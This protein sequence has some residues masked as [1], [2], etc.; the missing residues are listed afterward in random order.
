MQWEKMSMHIKLDY[1]RTAL[2]GLAF[3]TINAVWQLYNTEIPIMLTK[4]IQDLLISAGNGKWI[5]TD[6]IM[7]FETTFPLTTVVNTIMSVDNVMALFMLPFLGKLSDNTKSRF[8]KR[9]PYIVIGVIATALLLP[10]VPLFYAK[11]S[12]VGVCIMLGGILLAM[13][14]YR[15]PAVAL[16]PDVTPKPLR[17]KANAIINLMGAAGNVVIVAVTWVVG[18]L[19][20]DGAPFYTALFILTSVVILISLIVFL[21]TVKEP[22]LLELMPP[23]IEEAEEHV[24]NGKG[25]EIHASKRMSLFFILVAVFMW[26]MAYGCIE[27]NFSRYAKD[28]LGM[29]DATK[30]IPMLVAMVAA[31]ICFLPLGVLSSK[32]GRKKTVIAGVAVLF[33]CALFSSVITNIIILYVFFALIGISW[34]A[35]NVNSYPM[36]VEMAKGGNIGKYTGIYYTFQMAAQIITPILSAIIMDILYSF[37]MNGLRILFPYSAV[38]LAIALVVMFFVR[39]GDAKEADLEIYEHAEEQ[40]IDVQ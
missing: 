8:G 17:S 16:M 13:S 22:K 28:I 10:F 14:I 12:L 4:M 23:E 18:M 6:G 26:Y 32:I 11:D 7:T 35:I 20:S 38:F 24:Y 15:S 36:V 1:K 33:V 39:H 30:A 29:D 31:F 34:A 9:T 5:E 2:V 25:E 19:L 21:I 27:T 3:L 40:A 37:G